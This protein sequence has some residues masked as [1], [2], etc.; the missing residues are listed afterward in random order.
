MKRYYILA[1]I[2]MAVFTYI[3]RFIPLTF[4]RKKIKSRYIR[5]LLYYLPYAA[6]GALTFPGV[7]SATP[8]LLESL[9][10]VVTAVVLAY[11][12]RGLVVCAVSSIVVCYIVNFLLA[13]A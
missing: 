8:H 3:P 5:S 7:F 10:G 4:Y 11:K 13:L 1:V 2:C 6:L 9:A 12:G